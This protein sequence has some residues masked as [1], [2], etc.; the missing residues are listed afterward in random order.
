MFKNIK[1]ISLLFC[2]YFIPISASANYSNGVIAMLYG[3]YDL[4]V[5]EFTISAQEGDVE[6]TYS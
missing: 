1:I 6:A 2:A 3:E 4:A 5:K